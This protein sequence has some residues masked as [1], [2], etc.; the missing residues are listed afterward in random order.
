MKSLT[1]GLMSAL[2][3]LFQSQAP[4]YRRLLFLFCTLAYDNDRSVEYH[5][6]VYH[7]SWQIETEVY[8]TR[9]DRL[10]T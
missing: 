3:I 6:Y 9:H 7:Y 10:Y 8:L 4:K 1:F 5:A 2:R